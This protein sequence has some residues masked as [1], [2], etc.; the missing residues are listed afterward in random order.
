MAGPKGKSKAQIKAEDRIAAL[1]GSRTRGNATSRRRN[2]G[3]PDVYQEMLSEAADAGSNDLDKRPAKRQ[4]LQSPDYPANGAESENDLSNLPQQTIV[5][6]GESE[7]EGIDW[8][9][10][11]FDQV[12]PADQSSRSNNKS[13]HVFQDITVAEQPQKTTSKKAA[14]KRK[15]ITSVEKLLRLAV[16][17]AHVLFLI[18]H[19]HVRNSWCNMDSV[20][21]R[22]IH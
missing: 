11:E 6:S 18:F 22:L 1:V 13:E 9:E 17:E 15:P 21:V 7:D 4:R 20:Q 5:D 3:V 19:V 2:D 12:E 10:V 16:H 8:E 14:L